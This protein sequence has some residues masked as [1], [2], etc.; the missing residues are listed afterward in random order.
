MPIKCGDMRIQ[1]SEV[2]SALLLDHD[3]DLEWLSFRTASFAHRRFVEL[4]I[5]VVLTSLH[6]QIAEP[7]DGLVDQPRAD[8]S[9]VRMHH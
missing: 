5:T 8:L 9:D 7:T 6:Q 3:A 2:G 1:G 4:A